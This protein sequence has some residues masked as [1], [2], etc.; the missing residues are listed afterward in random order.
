MRRVRKSTSG[1]SFFGLIPTG[2]IIT[3]VLGM[4]VYVSVV[5]FILYLLA[6]VVFNYT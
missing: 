1:D 4:I 3:W 6:R 5:A 2:M